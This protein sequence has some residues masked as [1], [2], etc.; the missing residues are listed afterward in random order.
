MRIKASAFPASHAAFSAVNAEADEEDAENAEK[1]FREKRV[2]YAV[3]TELS[4]FCQRL[5]FCPYISFI[6]VCGTE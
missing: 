4:R 3:L 1:R 5:Q 6:F 2:D